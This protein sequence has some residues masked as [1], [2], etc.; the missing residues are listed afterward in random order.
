MPLILKVNGKTPEVGK[1][2]FIAENATLIGDIKIGDNCSVWFNAVLR[3]DV[4]P[5]RISD[6]V[7]IQDGSI[8]HCTHH[9]SETHIGTNVSIGHRAIIHGC[10]IQK[11]VLVGMGAILMDHS[12]VEENCIIG[13][14]ALV[15]ENK[16]LLSGGIYA[17]VPVKKIKD[18][19]E[20]HL[21][22]LIE[23]TAISYIKYSDWYR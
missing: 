2:C 6:N 22:G 8:V 10:T 5:I 20:G 19:D 1:N 15:P 13:A 23:Q 11:N 4:N 14:G 21:N 7:N 17:G 9:K 3:G 12:F 16:K 18:A